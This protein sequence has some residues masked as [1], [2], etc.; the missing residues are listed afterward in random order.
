M[1]YNQGTVVEWE[2]HAGSVHGVRQGAVVCFIPAEGSAYVHA[3]AAGAVPNKDV[4]YRDVS[5]I[6]R[7]LV[8]SAE[9]KFYA[10]KATI[11]SPTG[12]VAP[13]KAPQDDA[14]INAPVG[15]EVPED[16]SAALEEVEAEGAS[17]DEDAVSDEFG[18]IF[19][20]KY[21]LFAKSADA[22]AYGRNAGLG[23]VKVM[24]VG[25]DYGFLRP[26]SVHDNARVLMINGISVDG[27]FGVTTVP[28][29]KVKSD[30]VP[31]AKLCFE[32]IGFEFDEAVFNSLVEGEDDEHSLNTAQIVGLSVSY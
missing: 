21:V 5:S 11:V 26:S 3:V 17:E 30:V 22:K 8:Q 9:G 10:P 14:A 6:D 19:D 4:S 25:G 7:Y 23:R 27:P 32:G 29:H 2:Y 12:V 20:G 16:F 28:A 1:S 15:V 31:L 24:V 18:S 13:V